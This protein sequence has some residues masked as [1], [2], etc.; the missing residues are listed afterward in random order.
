MTEVVY[1]SILSIILFAALLVFV[2]GL[3]RIFNQ[4]LDDEKRKGLQL[5]LE[6]QENERR[7][8]AQE[9][10]DNLNPLLAIIH[11]QTES[12]TPSIQNHQNGETL[13]D[14]Q[15]QLQ[16]AIGICRNIAHDLTP[17]LPK[18][19]HLQQMLLDRIERIRGSGKLT[20]NFHYQ[21][22]GFEIL[23]QP[24][25]SI[26]RMVSELLNNTIKHSNATAIHLHISTENKKMILQYKDNGQNENVSLIPAGIGMSSINSRIEL[27][28]G[29]WNY[30]SGKDGMQASIELPLKELIA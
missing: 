2:A 9:V 19:S 23:P 5:M 28:N 11:M 13:S 16:Q 1:L 10:H 27:L 6:V 30:S 12:I 25:A 4:K 3:Y 15:K 7:L 14:I 20:I 22:N 8:I 17:F 21:L 29:K 26:F 24:A 18:Q